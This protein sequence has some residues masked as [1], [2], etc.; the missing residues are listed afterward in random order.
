MRALLEARRP[1]YGLADVRV[2]AGPTPDVVAGRI[3]EALA[4]RRG[5]SDEGR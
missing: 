2:D 4:A 1:A 5:P 3:E